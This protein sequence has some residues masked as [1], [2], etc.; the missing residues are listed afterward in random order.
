[1][2]QLTTQQVEFFEENG[3]VVVPQVLGSETLSKAQE[4]YWRMLKKCRDGVYSEFRVENQM[5][6]DHV[7]GIE[8]IFSPAIYEPAIF[9]ASIESSALEF[10]QQLLGTEEVFIALNRIHCT[11]DFSYSGPWHRDG[12]AGQKDHIQTAIV[13]Y[14]E[15]R[16][17]VIP[18]S[19]RC[20]TDEDSALTGKLW[21]RQ[22]FA[23]QVRLTVNS[24]DLLLFHSSVLHRGSSVGRGDQH[25]AYIHYR[26]ARLDRAQ[27]ISRMMPPEYDR[28]SLMHGLDA[29]W[30]K[31]FANVSRANVPF[32]VLVQRPRKQND[33]RGLAKKSFYRMAYYA[34]SF[35]PENHAFFTERPNFTPYLRSSG[36]KS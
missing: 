6:D 25:R 21:S 13:L 7:F 4:G 29:N 34:L 19:H 20:T 11:N 9:Q 2:K 5:S 17:F 8:R 35:L 27:E 28:N 22:H 16:F 3:Y 10:T 23:K 26:I 18:G 32:S 30:D 1:M 24:G 36:G 14:P 31:A 15:R 12:K 33:L